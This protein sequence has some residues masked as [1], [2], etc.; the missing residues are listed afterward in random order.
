MATFLGRDVK[1]VILVVV[2]NINF[3]KGDEFVT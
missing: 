3:L 1:L 2:S